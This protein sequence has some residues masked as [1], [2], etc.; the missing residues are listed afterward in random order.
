MTM[1]LIPLLLLLTA[2]DSP[3]GPDWEPESTPYNVVSTR[4][5]AGKFLSVPVISDD[6]F[7]GR[8]NFVLSGTFEVTAGGSRD[9]N[10]YVVDR[11]GY[12]NFSNG[13]NFRALYSARR[14]TTDRF[15]IS[16]DR[17]DTYYFLL[18][19]DFSILTSK[20][21]DARLELRYEERQ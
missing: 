3:L 2:C 1:I 10:A 18:S 14:T 9:I 13:N 15:S 17:A 8:R 11:I 20:T 21:V 5:S 7:M 19:N 16:L 12:K 6:E 4:I